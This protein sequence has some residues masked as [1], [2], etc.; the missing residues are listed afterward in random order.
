MEPSTDNYNLG[1]KNPEERQS[2]ALVGSKRMST[3]IE[4]VPS[5]LAINKN[6]ASGGIKG[7][8]KTNKV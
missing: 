8:A 7:G 1:L 5:P 2:F 6:N 3:N 4:L